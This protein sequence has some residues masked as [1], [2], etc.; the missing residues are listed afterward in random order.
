VVEKI[1]EVI[2]SRKLPYLLDV[3]DE[4][5]TDVAHRAGDQE[6]CRPRSGHGIPVQAHAAAVELPRQHD[7]PGSA[8][9]LDDDTGRKLPPDAPP[10]P[11]KMGIKEMLGHFLDF[12]LEVVERRFTYQLKQLEAGFIS[13]RASSRSSMRWTR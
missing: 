9:V 4:S 1:A 10:Q 13:W 8:W 7:L 3:R 5:T 11:R 6:G 2:V 12:R